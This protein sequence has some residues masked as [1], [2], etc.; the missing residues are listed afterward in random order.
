MLEDR[1]LKGLPADESRYLNTLAGL[2]AQEK[3]HMDAIA[4]YQSSI[5]ALASSSQAPADLAKSEPGRKARE[6]WKQAGGTTEGW[7]VWMKMARAVPSA[8]KLPD[9]SKWCAMRKV[10]PELSAADRSGATWTLAKVKGKTTLINV[11]ATWCGPCR[12][13]LPH[14]QKLHDQVK[15]REDVQVITLNVDDNIGLVEPYMKENKFTF[16]VIFA[17]DY[18]NALVSPLLVPTNWI[19]D[20]QGELRMESLGFGGDGEGWLAGSLAELE[21][22]RKQSTTP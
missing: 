11:W 16:P 5:R 9:A 21:N 19:A 7:Q 4:L 12:M 6:L 15:A 10:L 20:R 8:A 13:E 2:A 17:N 3:R 18:V 14:L 1:V 22:V